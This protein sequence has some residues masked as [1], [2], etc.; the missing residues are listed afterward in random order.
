[1]TDPTESIFDREI[2]PHATGDG[3]KDWQIF[4]ADLVFAR[5]SALFSRLNA[6]ESEK[7][8]KNQPIDAVVFLSK[9]LIAYY[10]GYPG[11]CGSPRMALVAT[12]TSSLLL[13]PESEGNQPWRRS[14][15]N[16]L[17][18]KTSEPQAFKTNEQ[19]ALI[20]TIYQAI[21]HLCAS[22]DKPAE[23]PV[24]L[25][26]IEEEWNLADFARL[27]ALFTP[28]APQIVWTNITAP[29]TALTL[30]KSPE[31]Q[32]HLRK[33]SLIGR[34]VARTIMQATHPGCTGQQL[35]VTGEAKLSEELYAHFPF[36]EHG[37]SQVRVLSGI[38]CDTA[39][40]PATNQDIQAGDL[41][42][43]SVIVRQGGYEVPL[44]RTLF[45]TWQPPEN[46]PYWRT[47]CDVLAYG[48]TLL[49]PGLPVKTLV[50]K[51]DDFL[52]KHG[53]QHLALPDYGGGF[54]LG[55]AGGGI[56]PP[57]YVDQNGPD[58]RFRLTATNP[59]QLEEGMV[60]FFSPTLLVPAD[61]P[62]AG[63][64]REG[65]LVIITPDGAEDLTLFPYGDEQMI[66][67]IQT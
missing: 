13:V 50:K 38:D 66:V 10:A 29:V 52:Y 21:S 6:L 18:F 2:G 67:G 1:M 35:C 34:T 27:Q 33:L 47:V 37:E 60:I 62:G 57:F 44:N 64:Y 46:L 23:S 7:G 48:L 65:D 54:G 30:I 4:S 49:K 41:I 3:E 22:M 20:Q 15:G 16:I 63:L 42:S 40:G 28:P 5:L 14:A 19:Q 12:A 39:S 36:A 11:S 43:L 59:G 51:L 32:A 45:C 17:R 31:E 53:M 26:L 58:K 25:G 24:H 55:G 9:P 56:D 8:K 61:Q